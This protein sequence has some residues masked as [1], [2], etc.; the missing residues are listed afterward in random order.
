[1]I[2]SMAVTATLPS[3]GDDGNDTLFGGAGNDSISGGAGN[4]I[5]NG[6]AGNAIRL[7]VAW[8]QIF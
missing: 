7:S 5:I 6:G 4:D 2:R 3:R 8:A 1:M